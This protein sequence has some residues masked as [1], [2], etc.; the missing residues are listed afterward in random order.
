MKTEAGGSS[1]R[2]GDTRPAFTVSCPK[3]PDFTPHLL[4]NS[5]HH[6]QVLFSNLY[7]SKSP[8]VTTHSRRVHILLTLTSEFLT[9]GS[10][11]KFQFFPYFSYENT[12]AHVFLSCCLPLHSR[13]HPE[14][15]SY[16]IK[17]Q[18]TIQDRAINSSPNSLHSSCLHKTS[19]E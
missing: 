17:K 15:A 7:I 2:G 4:I 6:C 18:I 3:P 1:P 8:A 10:N 11:W 12:W 5:M 13:L 16:S 19:D 14:L 9:I